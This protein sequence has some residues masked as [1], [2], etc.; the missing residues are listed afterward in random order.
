M[1]G[2]SPSPYQE[3]DTNVVSVFINKVIDPEKPFANED[4]VRIA[5]LQ[6]ACLLVER[7][8]AHIHDG[9]ASNKRQGNKLRRLMTF[10]WPC[11]LG[12]NCV[13]PAARYHGHLL[14]SH[15]IA[16][17]A[18]HKRIVLQ[19]FHSLLKGHAVEA[20]TVV[21]QAL[22]VLTPAMPVRMEDGNTMLKHWTKKIIVEEGHS[23]QQLFH[24]LQLVVRH[25]KVYYV[26]RHNLVQHMIN[27]IQRLGFS[28]TATL[29]YRK[30]AVE[31]SE[32]IIKWEVQRIREETDGP[33]D[34]E[35]A[36][37]LQ[38]ETKQT[39][40]GGIKRTGQ[41]DFGES[42]KKLSTGEQSPP[43]AGTSNLIPAKIEGSGRPIERT[44]CDTVLNFLFRLACQVNDA[45][46]TAGVVSPGENLSR[47]CV[48]LIKVAMKPDVWPQ[49]C[50]LKLGWLDK[51]FASVES[52]QPNYGNI[53]TAL[54][55]LTFLLG[56][57]KKDQLLVTFRSLQRGLS[58]CVTCPST[59][60]I[61]LMHGLLSK[62]MALFP[63]DMYQKQEEL[64]TLYATVSKMIFD[65]LSQYE[66]SPQANISSLFGTLM[67]LKAACI[68][69]QSYIDRLM[70]P[71]MKLLNRLH[72]DHLQ[73]TN[74]AA[75][76]G[77]VEGSM[78][79]NF[80]YF[81]EFD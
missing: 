57:M 20:R 19:V 66:K 73:G 79:G 10:A 75:T 32:V 33:Y 56:V 14:L 52:P 38:N 46:P 81:Y 42:R 37:L 29:D 23:M 3:D 77:Q 63:T 15:I 36:N 62:L 41:D 44:H 4:A 47:R 30:L 26:V 69:N 1:V 61:R 2:A 6:F 50:D 39:A 45:A 64:E 49:P 51:V 65:G 48:T 72:K 35:E 18:I 22:E 7:A 8:S 16:R 11:L 24:I 71:F 28:P 59:R 27:S 67:I 70:M 9:D 76:L 21:R 5:L 74:T 31:L 25:F 68:N 55:L 58:A 13:D 54:E 17:L 60:V 12:K 80:Y 43:I 53:C 40:T 34:E 78:N